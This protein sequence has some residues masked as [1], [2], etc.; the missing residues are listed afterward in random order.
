MFI[1][2][3]L[4]QKKTANNTIMDIGTIMIFGGIL[5]VVW[6][7]NNQKNVYCTISD[8][9]I[10]VEQLNFSHTSHY[11]IYKPSQVEDVML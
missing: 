4:W 7:V 5:E 1:N 2:L 3:H 9:R 10:K 8:A 11:S 6:P